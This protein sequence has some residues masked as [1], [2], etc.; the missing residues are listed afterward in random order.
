LVRDIINLG[1][2]IDMRKDIRAINEAYEQIGKTDL[3]SLA[4]QNPS[5]FA[6]EVVTTDPLDWETQGTQYNYY[7]YSLDASGK[8]GNHEQITSR[9]DQEAILNAFEKGNPNGIKYTEV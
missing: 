2:N 1:I 5:N 7:L 8:Y 9:D 6:L 3:L 4:L